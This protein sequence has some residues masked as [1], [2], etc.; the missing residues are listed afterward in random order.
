M[1][2]TCVVLA[3]RSSIACAN[4]EELELVAA[5]QGGEFVRQLAVRFGIN[6]NTVSAILKRHEVST[7]W[8]KL[9]DEQ[10]E[11]AEAPYASGL[12]EA[13]V[14][15]PFGVCGCAICPCSSAVDPVSQPAG[16]QK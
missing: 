3:R 14:A 6:G 13:A 15:E 5:Y 8:R 12:S 1:T 9:S 2:P 10:L 16:T 4:L 11:Q 7:R